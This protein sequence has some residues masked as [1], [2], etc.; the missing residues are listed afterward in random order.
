MTKVNKISA[1]LITAL[2]AVTLLS[3]AKQD[4]V[5]EGKNVIGFHS[6][7]VWTK[8]LVSGVTDLQN[9]E[10]G[11]MVYAIG[12]F[13][14]SGEFYNFKRNVKWTT[15]DGVKGWN[16]ADLE[17]WLPTC[18]YDF[19]AYYPADF[20][21]T[22]DE[23]GMS[24]TSYTIDP[25]CGNQKDI[26]HATA[27]RA[28]E[29]IVTEGST[30][31]LSFMH[32]LSNL[33]VTLKVEQKYRDEVQTDADGNIITD[34]NGNQVVI[35]VPYNV[36]DAKVKAVAFEGVTETADYNGAWVEHRNTTSIGNNLELPIEVTPEGVRIFNDGL[37][38]IPQT[39]NSGDVSLYILADVV[40]PTGGTKPMSWN[41][42]IPEITWA[43]NTKYNYVA[44]LTADFSIE[45]EEPKVE[46]WGQEQISTGTGT[47]IIR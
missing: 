16:Y 5:V 32:L 9:D 41:L 7:E 34:A 21:A 18:T 25:Q 11:F 13:D 12:T 4:L 2:I 24:F 38:A 27:Q 17:Y 45:F 22:I 47:V 35:R 43:P 23:N 37:L 31:P 6:K 3:C 33:N 40:P 28:T 8:A 10:D 14:G 20:P 26:L 36:I 19:R 39:I 42:K 15:V 1:I 44:T 46:G 30:V 29:D